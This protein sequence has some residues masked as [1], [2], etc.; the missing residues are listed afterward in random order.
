MSAMKTQPAKSGNQTKPWAVWTPIGFDG[1][2][3]RLPKYFRTKSDAEEFAAVVNRWKSD[4]GRL[5]DTEVRVNETSL[6]WISFLETE[7]GGDLSKL[8]RIISHWRT[9]G[10]DTVEIDILAAVEKYVAWREAN[11]TNQRTTSDVSCRLKVMAGAFAGRKADTIAPGEM[12]SF[13]DGYKPANRERYFRRASQ[14]FDWC[15][16]QKFSGINPCSKLETPKVEELSTPEVYT[17]DDVEKIL[18]T[19]EAHFPEIFAGVVLQTFAFTRAAEV[20]KIDWSDIDFEERTI[21]IRKE[22]SKVRRERYI[23]VCS[24]LAHWL[25]PVRR[26]SGSVVVGKYKVSAAVKKAGATFIQNGLRHSCL[27]YSLSA[28]PEHGVALT[29][30]WSGN[31]EAIAKKH[32]LRSIKEAEGK[33]YLALRRKPV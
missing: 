25:E 16:M 5:V 10:S 17:V 24:V 8:P 31:S 1:Q 26:S 15:V 2:T 22:V 27:S 30:Q 7:L 19:A 28:N 12:Q 6:R 4:R 32:Y 18:T 29:A 33:R 13:L 20:Q 9:T 21:R 11:D 14:F 3:K 23:P